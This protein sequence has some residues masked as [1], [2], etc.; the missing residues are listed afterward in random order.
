[1][2]VAA[3]VQ[4]MLGSAGDTL[5]IAMRIIDLPKVQRE[6]GLEIVRRNFRDALQKFGCDSEQGCAWIDYTDR[7]HPSSYCG[8]WDVGWRSRWH[9]VKGGEN[10]NSAMIRLNGREAAMAAFAKSWAAG[11][12]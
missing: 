7:R 10:I 1:M 11:I 12:E 4:S 5:R 8:N 3:V 9:R 6:T 2:A